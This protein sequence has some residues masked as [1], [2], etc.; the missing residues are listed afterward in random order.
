MTSTPAGAT[1][2]L[3][4][5]FAGVTPLT[6]PEVSLGN[7]LLT[8]TKYRHA[9][10]ARI[11][12]VDK[13]SV[14]VQVELKAL[15][16]GSLKVSA[17]PEETQ[18]YLNGGLKG[19]SPV[20][21]EDLSPGKYNL[22]LEA[23]GFVTLQET[24]EVQA[25]QE[26][27]IERTLESKSEAYLLSSIDKEPNRVV[28][29]YDL[30]HHYLRMQQFERA[31]AM[32]AR[33]F[34][35]CVSPEVSTNEQR[36][37]YDEF[38]RVWDAQYNFTDAATIQKLHPRLLEELEKAIQRQP[39]NVSNY[40]CLGS[41]Y[42]KT[43]DWSKTAD[44]YERGYKGVKSP[45][46]KVY[47][48]HLLASARYN[49]GYELEQAGK[50]EEAQ[51]FYE[52]LVR[53]HPKAYFTR[54]ALTQ[55]ATYWLRT[56]HDYAKAIEVKKQFL[57][58]FPESDQCPEI[59][60]EVASVYVNFL[61]D[62]QKAIEE[63]RA[64]LAAY[65]R[66]DACKTAQ[67]TIA[68]LCWQNLKDLPAALRE[69]GK[70]VSDY[71]QNDSAPVALKFM[72]DLYSSMAMARATLPQGLTVETAREKAEQIRKRVVTEYPWS[73]QAAMLDNDQVS[74]KLRQEAATSCN[75]AARLAGADVA[76]AVA[77]YE[78]IVKKYPRF[79]QA[80]DAQ[81]QIINLYANSL[82]D[83]DKANAARLR[84]AELFPD[85]DQSPSMLFQSGYSKA[86]AQKKYEEGVADFRKLIKSYPDS[87]QCVSAQS[88][89]A[90]VYSFSYGH[91][92]RD[93]NN[94]EN[95]R[96]IKDY[97]WYDG[98]DVTQTTIG[99]NFYYQFQPGDKEKAQKELLKS[100]QDYPYGSYLATTEYYI[101]MV[102]AGAQVDENKIK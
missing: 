75:E 77:A 37:L 88:Y 69:Y 66:K 18:V 46:A 98:N 25:S 22:R 99:M 33:G 49:Q 91:Y 24:I 92:D 56:K 72:Y 29:Y 38:D 26:T 73:T 83:N 82:K 35:A 13:A 20:T 45:R 74:K 9:S 68:S 94:E 60:M 31:F 100:I 54:S 47:L 51:P 15:G 27:K 36:R 41:F 14:E 90:S 28:N 97:P 19:K 63:Y 6:L 23:D 2:F 76:K 52:A 43:K 65:P 67:L 30:A 62:Y 44:A 40:W 79:S 59:Q 39:R 8:L 48:E 96:L 42:Q 21:V 4:S 50:T 12:K 1:V 3:D 58:M 101:D 102:D 16:R 32:F 64:Y 53:D 17:L 7:H 93:K 89:I 34:D 61:K 85:S 84:Y 86:F 80:R 81:V 70:F 78:E 10:E 5:R 95:R 57:R 71:P 11:L 87:D 55:R